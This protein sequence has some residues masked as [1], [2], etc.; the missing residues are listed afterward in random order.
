[1]GDFEKY[2]QTRA[3]AVTASH[4]GWMVQTMDGQI[5]KLKGLLANHG[6]LLDPPWRAP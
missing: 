3:E 5:G 2:S 4:A 6:H 1:L